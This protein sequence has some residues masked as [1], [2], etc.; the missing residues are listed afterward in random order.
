MQSIWPLLLISASLCAQVSSGK[1]ALAKV[2]ETTLYFEDVADDEIRAL[3]RKL[4]E[5]LEMALAE[6]TAIILNN[7]PHDGDPNHLKD[8]LHQAIRGG[9]VTLMFPIPAAPIVSVPVG[10][11]FIGKHA[12][13]PVM[14]IEF[15]DTQCPFCRESRPLIQRL[16][17]FYRSKLSVATRH[18]PLKSHP[19][20]L[21]AAYALEC[22]REQDR[23]AFFYN[24]LIHNPKKQ[25]AQDFERYAL[26]VGVA[27]V[28]SFKD[29]FN[30]SRYK[31][32]V[33][34]DITLAESVGIDSTPSFVIGRFDEASQTVTG[35]VIAGSLSYQEFRELIDKYLAM[36][37]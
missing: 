13:A 26:Q 6:K 34:D 4:Y 19:G 9:D 22:A 25:S 1:Y 7:H 27:D 21:Q 33:Q 17:Q 11:A 37:P 3:H 28:D 15:M 16:K 32:L 29:C 35:E 30:E 14:L 24:A 18:F 5:K 12:N 23:F 8:H 10:N 20:A 36:V 31:V 2:K